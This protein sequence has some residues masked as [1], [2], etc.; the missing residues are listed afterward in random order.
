MD[1][2]RPV[3]Q[4]P[5]SGGQPCETSDDSQNCNVQACDKDCVLHEWT[6]WTASC[7]KVCGGGRQMRFKHVKVHEFGDNGK[8]P[9]FHDPERFQWKMCNTHA[10]E[11]DDRY[12]MTCESK[13]DVVIALDASGSMGSAGWSAVKKATSN[14]VAAMGSGVKVGAVAFSSSYSY[15]EMRWC[16]GWDTPW[17]WKDFYF[18]GHSEC[19]IK[20]VHHMTEDATAVKQAVDSA[21]A[22]FHGTLTNIAI[23]KAGVELNNHGR[24]Y[25]QSILIVFTDGYP[26]SREKTRESSAA[27]KDTGR[28][29]YVPVGNFASDEYFQEVASYPWQDN[30][31]NVD[32][33]KALAARSTLDRLMPNFCPNI[34]QNIPEEYMI[35]E[36]A[37]PLR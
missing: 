7:T 33:F 2:I 3:T 14:V 35:N 5:T 13:L 9:E 34:V 28:I 26:E 23:D 37:V 29:I 17:W 21:S 11:Y 19:G 22:D 30:L 1:R 16:M 20:W 15:F 18:K 6:E 25:A 10:C 8:C 36:E 27:F 12:P 4:H 32:D 24:G 31:V